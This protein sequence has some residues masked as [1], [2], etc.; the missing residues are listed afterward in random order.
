MTDTPLD[1]AVE[2]VVCIPTFRRPAWLRKTLESVFSQKTSFPF[3]VVVVDNDAADP[4]GY[5]EAKA[6]FEKANMPSQLEIEPS[7]GNCYAINRAFTSALEHYPSARWFLMIDDDEIAEPD[8]LQHMVDTARRNAAD[9]VGGPVIRTFDED[10]PAAIR[11]HAIFGFID[12]A[13]R[14]IDMIHGSGNCLIARHVFERLGAPF[15]DLRFNFLGGGD[16][17]FFTRCRR[18]GYRT[19]WCAEA[20]IHETVPADR[21]NAKWLMQRSMRI[22]SINYMIDRL[23]MGTFAGAKVVAKNAVSLGLG[24]V[25]SLVILLRTREMVSATHPLLMSVGR[26][27]PLLGLTPNPYQAKT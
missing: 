2:A 7:Q 10:V 17:E 18:A 24:V 12:G 8:W 5:R 13:S 4:A 26:M 1:S 19:W 3:A 27:A 23:H 21:S 9:V 16:M 14:E 22:G 11:N 25:R 6:M 15:F 20:I